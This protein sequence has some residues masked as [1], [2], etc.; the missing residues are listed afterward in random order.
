MNTYSTI[1]GLEHKTVSNSNGYYFIYALDGYKW[2]YDITLYK[3]SRKY[4]PFRN[5][6][7]THFDQYI[8][9]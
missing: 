1:G 8:E 7:W 3:S 5:L 9:F 2:K 6:L 4:S